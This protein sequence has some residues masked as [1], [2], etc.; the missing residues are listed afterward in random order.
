[1]SK[2]LSLDLGRISQ[3]EVG[4][5][6][7]VR[8]QAVQ[9]AQLA[10]PLVGPAQSSDGTAHRDPDVKGLTRSPASAAHG[11]TAP[12]LPENLATRCGDAHR[13]P[14]IERIRRSSTV[15]RPSTQ[16]LQESRTVCHERREEP[17]V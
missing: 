9:P 1:M 6:I 4:I 5:V 10:A 3:I 8:E 17:P 12:E 11:P 14:S 15:L 2:G 7:V 16:S 13:T